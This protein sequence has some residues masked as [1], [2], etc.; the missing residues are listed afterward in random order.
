MSFSESY[1]HFEFQPHSKLQKPIPPLGNLLYKGSTN[2]D[3][4]PLIS[5]PRIFITTKTNCYSHLKQW[6]SHLSTLLG[7]TSTPLISFSPTSSPLKTMFIG[8]KP[9]SLTFSQLISLVSLL[10]ILPYLPFLSSYPLFCISF[11]CYMV[12]WELN[13]VL[14][15]FSFGCYGRY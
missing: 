8:H 1:V 2:H 10:T 11:S 15:L 9:Q 7:N 3:P 13:I 5:Q 4:F 12:S 14:Y 6:I